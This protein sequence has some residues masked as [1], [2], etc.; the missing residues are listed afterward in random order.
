MNKNGNIMS[1][2]EFLLFLQNSEVA[3]LVEDLEL[4]VE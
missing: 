2:Q 4:E 1:A 3:A